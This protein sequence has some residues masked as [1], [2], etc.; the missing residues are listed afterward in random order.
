MPEVIDKASLYI[1]VKR[2]GM[3]SVSWFMCCYVESEEA[4]KC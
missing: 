2:T 3:Y 1:I 4:L